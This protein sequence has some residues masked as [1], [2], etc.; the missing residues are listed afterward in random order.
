MFLAVIFIALGLFLLLD[1]LG[2]I[3]AGNF[4]GLF[5]AKIYWRSVLKCLLAKESA[6]YALVIGGVE[7]FTK[8]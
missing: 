8:K 7:E 1:V 4:W 6:Q 2:I 3:V 5:W